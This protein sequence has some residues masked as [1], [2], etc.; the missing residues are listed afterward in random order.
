MADALTNGAAP[1]HNGQRG[2]S[3]KPS[4]NGRSFRARKG[5]KHNPAQVPNRR[6]TRKKMPPVES[7]RIPS[8]RLIPTNAHR[9]DKVLTYSGGAGGTS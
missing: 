2:E 5:G 1:E 8:P 3:H 4:Y 6:K 7:L 9:D